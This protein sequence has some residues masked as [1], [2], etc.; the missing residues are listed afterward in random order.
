MPEITDI[1]ELI[2]FREMTFIYEDGREEVALLKV[3]KPVECI[4][5]GAW[6]CP[7]ELSTESDRK[8]HA[9]VGGDTLQALEL[10]MKTLRVEIE[11]WEKSKRGRF[12][13]LG[14]EGACI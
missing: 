7:Y 13:F 4:E 6:H 14:E 3:G 12:W 8:I 9:M 11:F 10:T 2:A 5:Y 1:G